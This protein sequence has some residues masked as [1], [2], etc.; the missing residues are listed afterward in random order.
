MR[1]HVAGRNLSAAASTTAMATDR[2][3][4]S[5][6]SSTA[7]RGSATPG[8]QR[9]GAASNGV[10]PRTAKTASTAA[11]SPAVA[12]RSRSRACGS[13]ISWTCP[14]AASYAARAWLSRRR[15]NRCC[16]H[17]PALPRLCTCRWPILTATTSAPTSASDGEAALADEHHADPPRTGDVGTSGRRATGLAGV[18]RAPRSMPTSRRRSTP[19]NPVRA[20]TT[21]SCSACLTS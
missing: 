19:V 3:A 10:R 20:D 8:S 14:D 17:P 18:G 12:S 5:V 9:W 6:A 16:D 13:K 11:W 15:A 2:A 7:R 4:A 21:R 1:I